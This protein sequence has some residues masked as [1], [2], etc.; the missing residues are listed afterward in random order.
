MKLEHLQWPV[1]G[2]AVELLKHKSHKSL[3][4]IWLHCLTEQKLEKIESVS[5]P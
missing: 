1:E 5:S 2:G 4:F 3:R